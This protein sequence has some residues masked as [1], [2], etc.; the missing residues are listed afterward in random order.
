LDR[1]RSRPRGIAAA[2]VLLLFAAGALAQAASPS[3]RAQQWLAAGADRVR[4][5]SRQPV[6]CLV[7]PSDRARRLSVE[8]GRAAFRSPTVL[9]GQAA[10]AGLACETCH[11]A[12]RTNRDFAFP[13]VSG[14][15]GTADVTSSLFSTHRGDGMFNPR[16][17][18][19]L[20]GARSALK[21]DQ[22]PQGRALEGFIHGLVT[23][24]FDG[25]EPTPAVLGGLADYVRALSPTACPR[26]S[27]A[28][29]TLA[30]LMEDARRAV[31]AAARL[32]ASG[33]RASAVVMVQAARARLFLIDERYAD[34]VLARER[35]RL[36]AA[37]R[38]L[39]D[40][41]EALRR[42]APDATAGLARWTMDSET[43]EAALDRRQ[44][45]SLFDPRRLAAATDGRLPRRPS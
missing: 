30:G 4:A 23:Q 29:V 35:G 33:D 37:D 5:L 21:I 17:I 24:E 31:D 25:P 22:A 45:R 3:L 1:P 8:V 39:G 11:R 36:R 32:A 7:L 38:R 2:A 13:G 40:L 18:P 10:R 42:D 9:G 16:P 41:A 14:P 12:G 19:D 6:E 26:G 15:A 20:G 27:G 43:L 34:P 44:P 28:P